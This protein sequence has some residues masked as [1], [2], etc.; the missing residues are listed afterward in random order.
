MEIRIDARRITWE[1]MNSCNVYNVRIKI[2][3]NED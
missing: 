3:D 1:V 2:D